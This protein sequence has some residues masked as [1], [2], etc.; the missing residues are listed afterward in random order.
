MKI[1]ITGG[2]GFL[3]SNLTERLL[4]E[5]H[6]VYCVDDLSTGRWSNVK[7]L[8]KN[9]NLYFCKADI[10]EEDLKS[11]TALNDCLDA[12]FLGD[13]GFD[14][15]YHLASPASPPVY[16]K[17]WEKTIKVNTEGT[18]KILNF[19]K[20]CGARVCYF[21]TSEIYGQPLVVPQKETYYGNVN[22]FGNRSLYDEAKRLGETICFQYI[23]EYNQDIKIARIFN[24]YGPNLDINDGRV[25]V[26]FIKQ[27]LLGEDITIFG[28]GSQYR[29]YTYVDDMVEGLDLLMNS[30]LNTPV[31]LGS[32]D[33]YS[34]EETANIIIEKLL[35]KSK[36]V[37]CPIDKDDP[38]ERLPDLTLAKS[39]LGWQAKTSFSEGLDKTIDYVKKKISP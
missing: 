17:L 33:L 26:T 39:I 24:T 4:S 20:R 29:C 21:S 7:D 15:I 31:N 1:M 27:A 38:K 34:I 12:K 35:S 3:G 11:Q 14:Q 32:N 37:Y 10:L 30:N 9:K 19:A 13:V 2:A 16:T 6:E 28:D 18:F 25:I 8:L 5:G 36:I 22:S 23:K